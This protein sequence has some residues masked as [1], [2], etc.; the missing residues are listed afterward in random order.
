MSK[1]VSITLA[2]ALV[3]SRIDYCNALLYGI[4]AKQSR[5]LQLVQNTLCRIINHLPK[6]SR[7]SREL[8]LLHWLPVKQRITFKILVFTYKALHTHQPPYISSLLNPYSCNRQ[9]RRSNPDNKYL[10]TPRYQQKIHK[11][12]NHFDWSFEIAAPSLWNSLPP[13]VRTAPSLS[14]FRS[15]L[16]GHLFTLAFP[17]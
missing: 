6:Y 13:H 7:I 10:H 16:K 8:K 11:S 4:S 1:S 12:R 14:S 15:Q 17:P 9:T 5:R 3:T 2:N